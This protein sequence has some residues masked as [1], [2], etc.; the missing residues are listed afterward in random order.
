MEN[1]NFPFDLQDSSPRSGR[2]MT[3]EETVVYLQESIN[4][5]KRFR[6]L[7]TMAETRE[8]EYMCKQ[9]SGEVP[10]ATYYT[11]GWQ[12]FAL[13]AARQIIHINNIE[14]IMQLSDEELFRIVAE[15]YLYSPF[16]VDNNDAIDMNQRLS[17]REKVFIKESIK[18]VKDYLDWDWYESVMEKYDWATITGSELYELVEEGQMQIKTKRTPHLE[19]IVAAGERILFAVYHIP[20][21]RTGALPLREY[22]ANA[23]KWLTE[24]KAHS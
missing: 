12:T 5:F 8:Y 2:E 6:I 3:V 14:E 7:H 24:N 22:I 9:L 4:M 19:K 20:F 16:P 17:E 11:K 1:I 23:K 18:E 10:L 15:E 21:H 13:D